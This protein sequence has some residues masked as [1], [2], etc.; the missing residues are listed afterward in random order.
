MLVWVSCCGSVGVVV[1]SCLVGFFLVL[2]MMV[3]V[4]YL[5]S[6]KDSSLTLA[7]T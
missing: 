6:R 7:G 5:V 1:C 3:L 4:H 2:D